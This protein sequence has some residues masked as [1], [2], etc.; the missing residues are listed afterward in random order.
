MFPEVVTVLSVCMLSYIALQLL[1]ILKENLNKPLRSKEAKS[2]IIP[3]RMQSVENS[4]PPPNKDEEECKTALQLF[5][6]LLSCI[7]KYLT[8]AQNNLVT[9]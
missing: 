2:Y 5:V 7:I 1:Q 9:L 8:A 4:P 6:F 3:Q